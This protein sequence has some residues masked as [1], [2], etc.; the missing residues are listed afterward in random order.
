MRGLYS[1]FFILLLISLGLVGILLLQWHYIFGVIIPYF[2]LAVFIIGLIYRV[3]KWARSPVPFRIPTTCGQQKSLD[4]IKANNLESP[5]NIWGVWGR[6]AL[7]ILLFRSL[8][9][10]TKTELTDGKLVY[11]GNKWLWLGGL[12]FHWMFL[13]II[14]RHFRFFIEPVPSFVNFIQNLDGL[15]EI[16]VPVLY[17]SGVALLVAL[18][19]LIFRRIVNPQVRYISM[20]SDFL[21]LFLIFS[22][23][24]TGIMMRYFPGFRVNIVQV[25]QL[26]VGLINLNPVVPDGIGAMF[27]LHLF[28]VSIL[29][30]YFPFSKLVHMGGVFLSP[31]RN[32][33]NNSR[34]K[35]HINPW[36]YPVKVHTYEEWE[37]EFRDV[38]KDAGL[39]LEKE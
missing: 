30:L 21:P 39:P 19:Y 33:I 10:N 36:N 18:T 11:G 9:R 20:A 15:M 16:G 6:M 3:V 23:G 29:L 34:I 17:M 38:M 13:I 24:L 37:D 27:Y 7:E 8:F 4:G 35:R 26:A 25:K 31:T 5:H 2:A 12:V 14:V 28:L 22:I 1:L 32:L